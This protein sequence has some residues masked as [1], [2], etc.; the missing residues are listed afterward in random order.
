MNLMKGFVTD[1]KVW[2]GY[3][4][5]WLRLQNVYVNGPAF[6]GLVGSACS[7]SRFLQDQ[8]QSDSV[9]FNVDTKS[10]FEAQQRDRVGRPIPMTLGWH[11]DKVNGT[12][13]LFKEG[14]GFHSEMQVYGIQGIGSV[15]MVDSTQ[16]GS[17]KFLNSAEAACLC[18]DRSGEARSIVWSD[19]HHCL[20]L[21][22]VQS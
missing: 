7:F 1:P 18:R 20:E 11:I 6:V 8:L 4:G 19:P 13:Y 15:V 5:R 14:G 2:A 3:E 17:A 12:T 10:A 16:F 22:C 21:S 9:L